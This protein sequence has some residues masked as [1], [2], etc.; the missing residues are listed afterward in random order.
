MS[1]EW[2][3]G[4]AAKSCSFFPFP[5]NDHFQTNGSLIQ[6][7]NTQARTVLTGLLGFFVFFQ[8]AL[9]CFLHSKSV[10]IQREGTPPWTVGTPA[11]SVTDTAGFLCA[12]L[13]SSR[14]SIHCGV[15]WNSVFL[16]HRE[17]YMQ[18]GWQREQTYL[19]VFLC[20]HTRSIVP[21][22]I[23]PTI[24]VR[25]IQICMYGLWNMSCA[26]VVILHVSSMLLYLYLKWALHNIEMNG[27][28]QANNLAF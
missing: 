3:K 16:V 27:K 8:N 15:S 5:A 14:A 22:S 2:L 20:S 26:I 1:M 10:L 7:S 23:F 6:G 19:R 17:C 13:E 25:L 21:R 24:L 28:I 18:L 12:L 4:K 11:Y 9:A